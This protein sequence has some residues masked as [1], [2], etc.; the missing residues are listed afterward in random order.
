MLFI[1]QLEIDSLATKISVDAIAGVGETITKVLL[2]TDCTYKN[3]DQAIDLSSK[4]ESLTNR[5]TFD[6]FPED[7]NQNIEGLFFLEFT[8]AASSLDVCPS[9]E[10]T[11]LGVVANLLKYYDCILNKVL[12]IE[13]DKCSFSEPGECSES[14]LYLN[15]LLDSICNSLTFGFYEEAIKFFKDLKKSLCGCISCGNVIDNITTG[16]TYSSSLNLP[17]ICNNIQD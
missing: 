4:L 5:E 2:W 13:I 17:D 15:L 7:I 12:E 10:E 16:T 11:V 1:Q 14:V 8:V 9:G 3:E 6:I